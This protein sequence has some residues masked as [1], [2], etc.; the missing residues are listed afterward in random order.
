MGANIRAMKKKDL[1]KLSEIYSKVYEEFDVGEKWTPK[2]AYILLQYWLRRQPDLAFVAE[3]NGKIA[4]GFIAGIKPWWDGNHLVDGEIFVHP[5]FQRKGIGK[6]L[7]KTMFEKALKK[8]NAK[9][10]DTYTFKKHSFPLSWYKTL[11]FEENREWT[12]ISGNIK[13]V[14]KKLMRK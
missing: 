3:E 2:K 8:Y 6:A 9:V 4:G 5:D 11:G 12:M 10:W 14:L 13:R 1:K 7:S